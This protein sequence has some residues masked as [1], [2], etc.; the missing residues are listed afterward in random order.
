MAYGTNWPQN[1]IWV[2][3]HTREPAGA[4]EFGGAPGPDA[5]AHADPP[6]THAGYPGR[7]VPVS[8]PQSPA[9]I[10]VERASRGLGRR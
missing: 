6:P 4:S 10:S 7:Y 5:H 3:K 1:A 8:D 9:E 2:A